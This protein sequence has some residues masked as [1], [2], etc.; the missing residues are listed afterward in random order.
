MKIKRV[1]YIPLLY[2]W[3]KGSSSQ[4]GQSF[5]QIRD[6]SQEKYL[7]S[8]TKWINELNRKHPLN[9]KGYWQQTSLLRFHQLSQRTP[10]KKKK[11]KRKLKSLKRRL[12]PKCK[13]CA[14]KMDILPGHQPEVWGTGPGCVWRCCNYWEELGISRW[15]RA[16]SC[17][18][19]R[20]MSS[21]HSSAISS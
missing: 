4:I 15:L 10:S 16:A 8:V 1:I 14:C 12:H 3:F 13:K 19:R 7:C 5:V 9:E 2:Y 21:P 17:R 6:M 11:K 18:G 20:V